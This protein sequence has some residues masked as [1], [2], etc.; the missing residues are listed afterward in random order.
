MAVKFSTRL[1]ALRAEHALSLRA[2]AKEI[3]VTANAVLRWE[4]GEVTPT[5]EKM[6]EL[7]KFFRVEAGWLAW[8]LGDRNLQ[9]DIDRIFEQL[10]NCN[11]TELL[12][13]TGLLEAF[14][15]KSYES[16]NPAN[17]KP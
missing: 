14:K 6:I 1:R 3:G 8:G 16:A 7:G 5:R 10:R 17:P 12:A 9:V 13:I 11:E 2:L 4:K 15:E